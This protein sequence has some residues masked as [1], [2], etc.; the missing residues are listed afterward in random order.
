[1]ELTW[2]A[3]LPATLSTPTPKASQRRTPLLFAAVTLDN[4]EEQLLYLDK[5]YVLVCK[6]HCTGVQNVD[7]H[8][9]TQHAA[10]SSTERK[11]IVDYCRRWPVVAPQNVKL[12]PLLGLPMKELGE[13][14]DAFQCQYKARCSFGLITVSKDMLQKHCKKEHKQA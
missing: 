2:D 13:P 5:Y 10:I 3:Q 7:M 4:I 6:M 14:L 1:M 11:A 9:R 12:P 8:L